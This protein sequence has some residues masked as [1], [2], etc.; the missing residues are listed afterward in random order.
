MQVANPAQTPGG[1]AALRQKIQSLNPATGEVLAEIE[2]ATDPE[3][4]AAVGRAA[5][6]LPGWR[7]MSVAER[8]SHLFRLKEVLYGRRD[9]IAALITLEAGKPGR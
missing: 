4:E 8:A 9:E 3:V 2:A 7:S 1:Q 5:H 6:A